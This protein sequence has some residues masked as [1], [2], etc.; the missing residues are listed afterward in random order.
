MGTFR[1]PPV[2]L[3]ADRA[4]TEE[5]EALVDTGS[6]FTWI[7]RDTLDRLGVRSEFREE[8]ET[9]DERTLEREMAVVMVRLDGQTLPTLIIFG[10]YGTEPVIGAYTLEGFRLAP[11]P[12]I[13]G[14][15]MCAAS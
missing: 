1:H 6:S 9:I 3:G 7:P 5:V 15:S 8:F 10:D 12:S 2:I 4:K 14:S 11:D 13:G